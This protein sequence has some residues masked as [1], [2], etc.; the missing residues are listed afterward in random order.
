MNTIT[1][2]QP[3]TTEQ[4][5]FNGNRY[6][7][8]MPTRA[9]VSQQQNK[10]I[11]IF[12]QEGDRVTISS[13]QQ[14]Q[15][16]YSD[17]RANQDK[18]TDFKDERLRSENSR[19]IS[20]A[21]DGNL[22]KQEMKD[23]RKAIKRIDKIMT[24]ILKGGDINKGLA[25]TL[26]LVNKDSISGIEVNYSYEKSI[27]VEHTAV[28]G[29]STYSKEGLAEKMTPVANKDFDFINK[30]IDKMANIVKDSEIKPSKTIKPIKK[31][32]SRLLKELSHNEHPKKPKINLANVIEKGLIRKIKQMP[33]RSKCPG[34][35]CFDKIV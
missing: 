31:L 4:L 25:K 18:A 29:I 26:Q 3:N 16:F 23:V 13:G 9:L 17:Y 8:R 5:A 1:P 28:E 14:S 6:S 22:N 10:D 32:F 33:E 21:V 2:D 30:L 15:A 12:T 20:I 27:L 24:K 35:P 34:N 7:H 11:T 19:H